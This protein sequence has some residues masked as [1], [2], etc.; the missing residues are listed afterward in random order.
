MCLDKFLI[1]L[2]RTQPPG[3][4]INPWR[5][6]AAAVKVRQANVALYLAE[7]AERNP[8]V[9]LVGEA[10]GYRG[11]GL[12]GV[13][14][15]SERILLE[16]AAGLFGANSSYQICDNKRAPISEAS[17]TI[18][19]QALAR[20]PKQLPLIWNAFPFHPHRPGK[21]QSN[22]PPNVRELAM[23]AIFLQNLLKL[24]PSV[25]R[26]VAVGNRADDSLTRQGISHLKIRHPSHGGKRDFV[27]GL[28]E[29]FG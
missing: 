17:A 3:N 22:R 27:A 16:G 25:S 12:T 18:V 23:G 29:I 9:L 14:F 13:P 4:C 26:V 10:P 7:M 20:Y 8:T 11:C 1:K 6:R 2:R 15:S 28:E 5:G 24:F 19:W 21:V